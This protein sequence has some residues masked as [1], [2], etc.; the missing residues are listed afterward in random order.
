MMLLSWLA[1]CLLGGMPPNGAPRQENSWEIKKITWDGAVKAGVAVEIH[2]EYGDIRTRG[3]EGDILAVSAMVQKHKDDQHQL[4]FEV[5]R[6]ENHLV[7]RVVYAG[8]DAGT[9]KGRGKRRADVTVFLP[10]GR[11]LK[12]RTHKGLIEAKGLKSDVDFETFAGKVFCRIEGS[13]KIKTHQGP[14]TAIL[15]KAE[16]K[17]APVL[18]SILGNITLQLPREANVTVKASTSGEITTDY[19]LTIKKEPKGRKHAVARIGKGTYPLYINNNS[20]N[21]K[22]LEGKWDVAAPAD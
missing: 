20:G 13:L 19:S 14:I 9:I 16:W 17:D 15:M 7:L 4:K 11:P 2:N 5:E 18:E 21:V 22:I 6:S 12:V 1:L 3:A 10:Y 8:D